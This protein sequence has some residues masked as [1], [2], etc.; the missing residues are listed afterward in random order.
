MNKQ[1]IEQNFKNNIDALSVLSLHMV[2]YNILKIAAIKLFKH[3]HTK[4]P[5]CLKTSHESIWQ[6]SPLQTKQDF[7]IFELIL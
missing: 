5:L 1:S 6:I 2:Y 3:K 7:R 4:V